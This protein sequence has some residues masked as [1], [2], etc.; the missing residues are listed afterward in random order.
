MNMM[1]NPDVS[2]EVLSCDEK[3]ALAKLEESKAAERVRVLEYEKSS[4]LLRAFLSMMS[5]ASKQE[6][7]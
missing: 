7:K 1:S 4:F 3:I 5:E 2:R 6:S